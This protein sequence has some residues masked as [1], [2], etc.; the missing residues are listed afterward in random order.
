M[1][2]WDFVNSISYDKRDL[3]VDPQAEKE[4]NSFIVNRALSQYPDCIFYA[5]AA[6][7]YSNIPKKWQ[8]DLLRYSIP[9][10]KRFSK[11]GKKEADDDTLKLIQET[12]QI[13]SNKARDVLSLLTKEQLKQLQQDRQQLVGGA[14]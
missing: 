11:W 8:Y 10:R 12:Y 6:N 13:S 1:N 7:R 5:N 14:K 9:A 2:V 3:F 4:Y